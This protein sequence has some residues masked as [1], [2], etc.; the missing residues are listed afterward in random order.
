MYKIFIFIF[1]LNINLFS[2]TKTNFEKEKIAIESILFLQTENWNDGNIDLYM[3]YYWNSDSLVFTSG[4]KIRRGFEETKN[5]YK[6][7]YNTKDK[8]GNLTFSNLEIYFTSETSAYV[9]GN[10]FLE[11]KENS[12]GGIFSLVLKKFETNWKII[13]DHTSVMSN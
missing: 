5:S 12:V 3:N 11:R 10:W 1:F 9:I 2:Q 6:K 4:G 8:M 7:N 13:H